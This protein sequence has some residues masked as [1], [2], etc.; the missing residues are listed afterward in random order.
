MNDKNDVLENTK[1]KSNVKNEIEIIDN[2]DGTKSE[3]DKGY[4]AIGTYRIILKYKNETKEVKV[5]VIFG[6]PLLLFPFDDPLLE[7]LLEE[8]LL[9]S[10]VLFPPSNGPLLLEF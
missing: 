6:E 10:L 5:I 7:L 9:L 3:R 4:A 2:G 8:P 1:L